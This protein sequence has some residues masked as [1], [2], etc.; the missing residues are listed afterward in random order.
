MPASPYT[1]A[2]RPS[3]LRALSNRR[4]SSARSASRSRS[5]VASPIRPMGGGCYGPGCDSATLQQRRGVADGRPYLLAY[6]ADDEDP[7]QPAQVVTLAAS[8]ST[9]SMRGGSESSSPARFIN[10]AA[11]G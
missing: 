1:S 2:M 3:P 9:G 7:S 11:I 5:S 4:D 8:T 6:A 10:A